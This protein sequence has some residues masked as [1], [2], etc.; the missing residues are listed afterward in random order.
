MAQLESKYLFVTFERNTFASLNEFINTW[1]KGYNYLN[2][3]LYTDIIYKTQYTTTD[4]QNLFVWKNGMPL[5]SKKEISFQE[6]LNKKLPIIN[7]LKNN[8][9][10]D[11]FN[12]EFNN[13]SSVWRI[14]LMHIIQPKQYPIFDQHVYRAFKYIVEQEINS[15]LPIYDKSRMKIYFNEYLPF[16]LNCVEN[17]DESFTSKQLD[18]A[19]WMFGKFLN[20]YPKLLL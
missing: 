11:R 17:M 12:D 4:L 8:W 3:E 18:D 10:E 7:E 13:I 14:F 6:K 20:E 15:A 19:L 9:E 5:S 16:Y 2:M 1:A